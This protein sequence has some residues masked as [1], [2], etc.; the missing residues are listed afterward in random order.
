VLGQ[1]KASFLCAVFVGASSLPALATGGSADFEQV[2][3]TSLG[4]DRP[5]NLL[6]SSM[7][8]SRE[9]AESLADQYPAH[10]YFLLF[11]GRSMAPVIEALRLLGYENNFKQ[12]P[13]SGLRY[14]DPAEIRHR[15]PD[16][17]KEA[18]EILKRILPTDEELAGRMVVVVDYTFDGYSFVREIELIQSVFR[19]RDPEQ[20]TVLGHG[21]LYRQQISMDAARR[22]MNLTEYEK[23]PPNLG[24][25]W[26]AGAFDE[27]AEV[28]TW[29]PISETFPTTSNPNFLQ[30]REDFQLLWQAL[31]P[32]ESALSPKLPV[33]AS[34]QTQTES[35]AAQWSNRLASKI[36][37]IVSRSS[38]AP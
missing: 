22:S 33:H 36:R 24:E 34:G 6:Q 5:T 17:W 11:P 30:F 35:L 20:T 13:L 14:L 1:F 15:V 9:V 4:A 23:S 31:Y 7:A 29:R 2:L 12:F 25:A 28:R 37:N 27:W 19:H 38:S 32:C 3:L 18:V 26:S 10:K 8:E 16:K 21:Y